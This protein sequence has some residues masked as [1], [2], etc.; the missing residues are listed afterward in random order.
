MPYNVRME[1]DDLKRHFG[2]LAGAA[3]AIGRTRQLVN[4][5]RRAGEIPMQW[6]CVYEIVTNG[7]LRADMRK[8]GSA[9]KLEVR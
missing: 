6:Q 8:S 9:N 4:G 3:R 2:S 1:I 7:A 5:W